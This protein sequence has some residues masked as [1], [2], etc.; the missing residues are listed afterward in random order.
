[1]T[2]GGSPNELHRTGDRRA[3]LLPP[4]EPGRDRVRGARG[5]LAE[6]VPC[7]TVPAGR[8]GRARRD[9]EGPVRAGRGGDGM[10]TLVRRSVPTLIHDGKA[11]VEAVHYDQARTDND[12]IE[13]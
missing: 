13:D 7:G 8:E 6:H 2:S 11:W 10:T 1:M 12:Y 5:P 3:R 4:R 9:R